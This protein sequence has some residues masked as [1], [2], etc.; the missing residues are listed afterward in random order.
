MPACCTLQQKTRFLS[1][2]QERG[3]RMVPSHKEMRLQELGRRSP[4]STSARAN[5]KVTEA[6]RMVP[7]S[8][9]TSDQIP[10]RLTQMASI[11]TKPRLHRANKIQIF[12][13]PSFYLNYFLLQYFLLHFL[14]LRIFHHHCKPRGLLRISSFSI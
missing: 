10:D 7:P 4:R 6:S 12:E 11:R 1:Q 2:R 5:Q 8:C 3:I 14:R 9:N 13:T